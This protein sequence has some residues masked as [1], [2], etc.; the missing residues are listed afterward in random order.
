[1]SSLEYIRK[2]DLEL[3]GEAV[4]AIGKEEAERPEGEITDEPR[5]RHIRF[6]F[7]LI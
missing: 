1:M 6:L 7:T 5:H 4:P 2:R 3:G